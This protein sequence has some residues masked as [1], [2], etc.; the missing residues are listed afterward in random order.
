MFKRRQ[1]IKISSGFLASSAMAGSVGWPLISGKDA[2]AHHPAE[3][4]VPTFCELCFWRCGVDAHVRDGKVY[5]ITGQENHPLSNGRLGPRG[6][7]GHGLL[8]DP[9]GLNNP[10]I[11]ETA[12]GVSRFRKAGGDEALNLIA[13]KIGEI[14]EK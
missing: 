6:T 11:R 9:D 14:T 3:K 4:V 2:L 8:F 10:P 1:F 12:D 5:K 7:G 13:K